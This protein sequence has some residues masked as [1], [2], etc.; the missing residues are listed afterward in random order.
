M[1]DSYYS[2]DHRYTL[3]YKISHTAVN[4]FHL[5][6]KLDVKFVDFSLKCISTSKMWNK[7]RKIGI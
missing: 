1:L 2:S 5:W 4:Y 6:I 7:S 3:H